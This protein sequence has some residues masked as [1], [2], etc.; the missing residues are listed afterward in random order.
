MPVPLNGRA[1]RGPVRRTHR[2]RFLVEIGGTMITTF[3]RVLVAMSMAERMLGPAVAVFTPGWVICRGWGQDR[4][5]G[6]SD[7][8]ASDDAAPDCS[9]DE[10]NPGRQPAGAR[11][12]GGRILEPAGIVAG[13]HCDRPERHPSGLPAHE[14]PPCATTRSTLVRVNPH[15]RGATAPDQEDSRPIQVSRVSQFLLIMFRRRSRRGWPAQGVGREIW[16]R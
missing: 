13:F 5:E 7:D 12:L 14:M 15:A 2:H 9:A 10:A 4:D 8:G 6:A 1:Y 3:G 16:R 11:R